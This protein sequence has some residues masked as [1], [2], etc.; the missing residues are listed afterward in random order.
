MT[1]LNY[2]TP[3]INAGNFGNH[4]KTLGRFELDSEGISNQNCIVVHVCFRGR[5][6]F[7]FSIDVGVILFDCLKSFDSA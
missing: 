1:F 6:L 4:L 2:D 5:F 7:E 3:L